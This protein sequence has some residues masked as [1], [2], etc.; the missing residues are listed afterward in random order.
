MISS[1][2]SATKILFLSLPA[3]K[4]FALGEANQESPC[5]GKQVPL[6]VSLGVCLESEVE[7][8]ST[9]WLPECWKSSLE[10]PSSCSFPSD[11]RLNDFSGE[12]STP[13]R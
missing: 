6:K 10:S 7:R 12:T 5:L 1:P 4:S 9:T 3:E 2:L 11:R 13:K 8:L